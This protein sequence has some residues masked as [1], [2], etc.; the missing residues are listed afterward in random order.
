MMSV[1]ICISIVVLALFGV[2]LVAYNVGLV[3]GAARQ[4]EASWERMKELKD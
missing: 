2:G 1:L 3:L 4:C